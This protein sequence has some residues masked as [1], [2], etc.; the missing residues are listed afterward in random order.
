MLRHL[1]EHV[2]DRVL[3]GQDRVA[4]VHLTEESLVDGGHDH[5]A[6][7]QATLVHDVLVHVHRVGVSTA[8]P[9]LGEQLEELGETVEVGGAREVRQ[10]AGVDEAPDTDDDQRLPEQGEEGVVVQQGGAGEGGVRLTHG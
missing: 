4:V 10:A 5:L 2:G 9:H 8:E 3:L 1:P 7:Q 6:G